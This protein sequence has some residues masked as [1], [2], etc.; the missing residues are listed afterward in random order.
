MGTQPR[1]FTGKR[2]PELFRED[3]ERVIARCYSP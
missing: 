1:R 2:D 3:I